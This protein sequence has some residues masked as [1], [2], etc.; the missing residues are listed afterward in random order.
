MNPDFTY[1]G[2]KVI[3]LDKELIDG[4]QQI[5]AIAPATKYYG[6][7]DGGHSFWASIQGAPS[8]INQE[9]FDK[10]AATKFTPIVDENNNEMKDEDGKVLMQSYE[11]LF[12]VLKVQS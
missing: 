1:H 2:N 5:S 10:C 7:R 9:H 6:K 3:H 8:E 11:S 12:P 4:S